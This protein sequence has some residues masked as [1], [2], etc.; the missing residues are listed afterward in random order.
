MALAI[1]YVAAFGQ[2]DT[3]CVYLS[4]VDLMANPPSISGQPTDFNTVCRGVREQAEWMRPADR[5]HFY[6]ML[7]ESPANL[8]YILQNSLYDARI[9][10]D[11]ARHDMVAADVAAIDQM[12][13][14]TP[15]NSMVATDTTMNSDMIANNDLVNVSNRPL[16]FVFARPKHADINYPMALDILDQGRTQNER[17][18]LDD[19]W[20]NTATDRDKDVIVRMLKMDARSLTVPVYP[21]TLTKRTY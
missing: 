8:G 7:W 9:Q 16:K 20:D 3:S 17:V 1:G 13:Q 14:T 15:S 19:W 21:S 10:A 2:S 11:C 12:G 5:D 18:I 6:T 4:D